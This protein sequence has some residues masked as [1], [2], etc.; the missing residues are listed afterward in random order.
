MHDTL[1]RRTTSAHAAHVPAR[2]QATWAELVRRR[3]VSCIDKIY[4]FEIV[5]KNCLKYPSPSQIGRIFFKW[6][7]LKTIV[8]EKWRQNQ[9]KLLFQKLVGV[10]TSTY[11]I[12]KVEM[13]KQHMD[14]VSAGNVC[15]LEKYN[16]AADK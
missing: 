2:F 13:V 10:C 12:C 15:K 8:T 9:T 7:P 3:G 6:A 14:I 16:S 1:R 5:M 11:F 4:I